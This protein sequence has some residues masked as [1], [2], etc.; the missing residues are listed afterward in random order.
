MS[1]WNRFWVHYT[2]GLHPT[3]DDT[4]LLSYGRNPTDTA[5]EFKS[6]TFQE[7][8]NRW[9]SSDYITTWAG[10]FIFQFFCLMIGLTILYSI[11]VAENRLFV[12]GRSLDDLNDSVQASLSQNFV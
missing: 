3:A 8:R 2:D 7:L 10:R 11:A 1:R 6:I 5:E 12:E 9:L 4:T